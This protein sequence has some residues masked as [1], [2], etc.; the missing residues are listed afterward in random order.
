MTAPNAL[1]ATHKDRAARL[2]RQ[3]TDRAQ[4]RWRQL[5]PGNLS[6]S[7]EAQLGGLIRIVAAGQAIAA[8]Q[9]LEY[10]EAS[11]GIDDAPAIVPAAFAG[12][13][14]DGRSLDSLLTLPVISTKQAI[15]NGVAVPEA[16]GRG[17]ARLLMTVHT[18]VA[19]AGRVAT[20]VGITARPQVHGSVRVVTLP[21]CGRCILLSGRVYRWSDGF[22]RHPRCD[23]T[24]A[25]IRSEA[26]REA[27]SPRALFDRMTPAQQDHAVGI[28][29]AKAIRDGADF[30]RV[31]N[32][33]R[34]MYTAGGRSLTNEGVR[35]RQG[36]VRLT[37]EQ[38]YREAADDR[39][40]AIRLLGRFGYITT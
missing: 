13:A 18:E 40:E 37:P 6:G 7:W 1:A 30:G 38:I 10:V 35:L 4:E 25:P 23:C 2:A 21:A 29:G 22:Q 39:A 32:A 36:G 34:G 24:M 28:P 26:G 5:D 3:V 31:V 15:G 8:V 33:Q 16:M 14:A 19:D 20:G 9:A 12:V 27:P 17:L 11:T